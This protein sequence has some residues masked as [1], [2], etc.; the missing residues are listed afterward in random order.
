MTGL[1]SV[2]GGSVYSNCGAVLEP[3]ASFCIGCGM[4]VTSVLPESNPMDHMAPSFGVCTTC[5]AP[6]DKDAAFCIACG[7]PVSHGM[8]GI[9]NAD[10]EETPVFTGRICSCGMELDADT[11]FCTRCGKAVEP[12]ETFGM[13]PCANCGELVGAT[14]TL[15]P[16]CGRPTDNS[17]LS[18]CPN[19]GAI[20]YPDSMTCGV[21]GQFLGES[22]APPSDTSPTSETFTHVTPDTISGGLVINVKNKPD[23]PPASPA[24]VRAKKNFKSTSDFDV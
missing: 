9:G 8:D 1:S 18:N 19:C 6:I 3:D 14:V 10:T 23:K 2:I 11:K 16:F 24:T 15:C 21:C 12:I 13:H 17:E 7:T 22:V 20:V 4:P 5:G